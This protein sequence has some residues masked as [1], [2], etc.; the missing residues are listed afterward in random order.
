ML[1]LLSSLAGQADLKSGQK[2]LASPGELACRPLSVTSGCRG[3]DCHPAGD[4]KRPHR[5]SGDK[6]SRPLGKQ[7]HQNRVLRDG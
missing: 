2:D 5:T 6:A 4:T 1:G 7:G 3:Q